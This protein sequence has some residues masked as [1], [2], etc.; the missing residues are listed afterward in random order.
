MPSSRFNA[1]WF[2]LPIGLIVVALSALSARRVCAS[3]RLWSELPSKVRAV[4]IEPP[5]FADLAARLSPAVVN[6]AVEQETPAAGTEGSLGS[7]PFNRFAP[8]GTA[9]EEQVHPHGV[10]SGF[11]INKMGFILTNDH[12]VAN[13]RSINVT[14]SDGQRY[15]AQLIGRDS[16]TD[17]ALIKI[18]SKHALPVAPLGDSHTVKV[19]AWVMAIGNPFGFDHT[20]TVGIV[21]AKGRFIPGNYDEFLQTD[22]SINPGN[23]GGPLIDMSGAVVG[24]NSAIY[25]RTGSNTGI[26]FAIPIDLVK[27]EL[28]ELQTGHKVV[29]GWLGVYL[30]QVTPEV[31]ARHGLDAPHGALVDE[32]IDPSPA[33][34]AGLR[35]GDIVVAYN[36]QSIGDSQELPLL[37]G[38]TPLGERVTVQIVRGNSRR[39]MP[40]TIAAS[41]EAELIAAAGG[42]TAGRPL[43]LAV[44][45]LDAKLAHQLGLG[46]SG[47]LVDA[48]TPGSAA[49]QAGLQPHDI[50]LEIN[51]RAVGNVDAYR[52][53]L[54]EESKGKAVLLLVRRGQSAVFVPVVPGP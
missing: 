49:A 23:S 5:D 18:S 12:V 39:A 6:I 11:L 54:K 22:A 29:R 13:A 9:P 28:P 8:P 51:R 32:V 14:T 31:A 45:N 17:V 19:G 33:K 15:S 50:I 41:R 27:R 10:G 43:G 7:D 20:V 36:G 44:E 24:V 30:N 38:A 4:R 2:L 26:S 37:V 35:K 48:V 53:A 42:A 1:S 46:K 40:V 34:A 3:E 52:R 16:K 47:V 25:T 21:S